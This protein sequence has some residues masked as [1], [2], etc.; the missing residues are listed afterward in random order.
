[1]KK[2]NIDIINSDRYKDNK[3]IEND[4]LDFA[5]EKAVKKLCDIVENYG[6]G[7]P[8]NSP[9]NKNYMLYT[10]GENN[11]WTCGLYTGVFVLAYELTGDKKFLDIV[12]AQIPS[13]YE[14]FEKRVGVDDHDV[15]FCYSPSV[16]AYYKLTGD[17]EARDFLLNLAQYFYNVS[18]SKNGHF[19]IRSAHGLP[20]EWACRT[21]M[22]TLMNSPFFFWAAKESNDKRYFEAGYSQT[23]I[24]RDYLIRDDGS[25]YHHYQFDV[26][27]HKPL[28]GLT[29]QG[30][31]NES[32]WSRGHSWG[33]YG[34]P[35]AYDY[36][37]DRSFM[38]VHS[39][40]TAYFL[41]NL[42]NDNIP[43]WDFDFS[44]GSNE[45]RD[46]SAGLI[47]ACGLLE[48]LK[49]LSPGDEK[50]ELYFNAANMMIEAV[51][52]NYTEAA[53]QSYDGLCWGVTG[54]KPFNMAIEGC[55]PYGDYFYLESLLRLKKP[56][57]KRYW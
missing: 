32:T 52:D 13:F 35:V 31:R 22:D 54:A 15:G 5:I 28:Y 29:Y 36:T 14:R 57:W 23:K 50:R 20:E 27:T 9:K 47:S 42:P 7:F 21:M 8:Q 3:P 10:M 49:Y 56:N 51:I 40:V 55:T 30:N 44:D 38:D 53:P 11:S 45:P 37:K 18:Y 24:T 41:N 19:I 4:K 34:F 2:T 43:Y 1:M 39:S 6:N 26:R 48:S 12:K 25:S 17:K 33:V 46:T 16:L